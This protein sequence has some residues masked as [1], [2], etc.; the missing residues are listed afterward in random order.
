MLI[1]SIRRVGDLGNMHN[2]KEFVEKGIELAKNEFISK[3]GKFASNLMEKLC[4]NKT[5]NHLAN[6]E[7]CNFSQK[8][9]LPSCH[10]KST[11]FLNNKLK[12][13]LSVPFSLNENEEHLFLMMNG[14]ARHFVLSKYVKT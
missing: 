11:E 6:D 7:K 9:N 12:R 2:S 14:L 3:K 8:Y 4:C 1:E 10:I 13:G 5:L